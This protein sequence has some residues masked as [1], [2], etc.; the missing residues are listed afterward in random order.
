M[1]SDNVYKFLKWFIAIVMPASAVLYGA[2]GADWG[3]YNP[4]LIVKTI[5]EVQLFLGTIFAISCYNYA[6]NNNQ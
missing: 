5:N 6:K 4:D 3:W 1:V 2:L